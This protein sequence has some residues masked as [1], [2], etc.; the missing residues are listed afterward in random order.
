MAYDVV[1]LAQQFIFCV[2]GEFDE[3]RIAIG[4]PADIVGFADN[5]IVLAQDDFVLGESELGSHDQSFNTI[6]PMFD[7]EFGLNCGQQNRLCRWLAKE[8]RHRRESMRL[9]DAIVIGLLQRDLAISNWL[10]F[11]LK[12][13]LLRQE[14]TVLVQLQQGSGRKTGYMVSF[15][16]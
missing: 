3:Y 13:V 8:L 9:R 5:E 14:R 7:H 6:W 10:D 16:I 15:I 11:G 4:Q 1:L 12:I 2:T